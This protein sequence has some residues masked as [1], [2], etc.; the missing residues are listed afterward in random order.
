[1]EKNRGTY[2]GSGQ[3]VLKPNNKWKILQFGECEP[4][5]V[6]STDAPPF[7]YSP[8]LA[9]TREGDQSMDED[10]SIR[11]VIQLLRR[12]PYFT[13]LVN[14]RK[15]DRPP[16]SFID[17]LLHGVHWSR[18]IW[19]TLLR[20]FMG[21]VLRWTTFQSDE[22]VKKTGIIRVSPDHSVPITVSLTRRRRESLFTDQDGAMV[23]DWKFT[24]ASPYAVGGPTIQATTIWDNFASRQPEGEFWVLNFPKARPERTLPPVSG[25]CWFLCLPSTQCEVIRFRRTIR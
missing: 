22:T 15:A 16:L 10:Y 20:R 18:E 9:Y 23:V 7:A 8:A 2:P 5:F 13:S 19:D 17:T 1:M 6:A 24:V 25:Q 12:H 14:H 3:T 21:P 4:L 11:L